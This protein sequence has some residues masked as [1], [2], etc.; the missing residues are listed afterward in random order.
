MGLLAVP[1]LARGRIGSFLGLEY[2]FGGFQQTFE[3]FRCPGGFRRL[4]K[5]RLGHQ[6]VV[7]GFGKL[8][9]PARLDID[10]RITHL[11]ILRMKFF[12]GGADFRVSENIIG[13]RL[14]TKCIRMCSAIQLPLHPL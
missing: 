7:F 10:E 8:K 13:Q 2:F 4:R 5:A 9:P 1:V 14:I 11:Q 12:R 3:T 6:F